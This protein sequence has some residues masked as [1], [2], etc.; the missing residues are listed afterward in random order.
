MIRIN[1]VPAFYSTPNM[2]YYNS[3]LETVWFLV[4]VKTF[5]QK[6]T[7]I[8]IEEPVSKQ[9]IDKSTI[10]VLLETVFSIMSIEGGYE[11]EFS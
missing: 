3:S 2:L 11:E 8:I 7:R 5:L 10:G 1:Y 4:S 9:R 6:R